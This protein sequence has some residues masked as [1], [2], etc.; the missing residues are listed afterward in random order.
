ML[1]PVCLMIK[2]HINHHLDSIQQ[3]KPEIITFAGRSALEPRVSFFFVGFPTFPMPR[4]S[5]SATSEFASTV[6]SALATNGRH[7]IPCGGS[8]CSGG[9]SSSGC[10]FAAS[11]R[12]SARLAFF[13][14]A[15]SAGAC[16]CGFWWSQVMY[17]C[18]LD[19]CETS[20]QVTI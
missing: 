18:T 15:R 8:C 16:P 14:S 17:S 20:C 3:L 4:T 9:S 5:L 19:N 1:G 7:R 13:A 2:H 12:L 11:T 10:A 6:D